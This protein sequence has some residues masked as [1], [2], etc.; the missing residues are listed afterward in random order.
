LHAKLAVQAEME[1]SS[2]N[3]WMVATLNKVIEQHG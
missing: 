1:G 3:N 2:L